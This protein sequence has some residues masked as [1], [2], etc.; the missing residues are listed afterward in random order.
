MQTRSALRVMG[1]S[2]APEAA[3]AP[4][5]SV[6]GPA[7]RSL[8]SSDAELNIPRMP[9]SPEPQKHGLQAFASV[10]P[11]NSEELQGTAGSPTLRTTPQPS[12]GGRLGKFTSFKQ[13]SGRLTQSVVAIGRSGSRVLGFRSRTE[14]DALRALNF[15]RSI[16]RAVR[17]RRKLG[18]RTRVM[19]FLVRSAALLHCPPHPH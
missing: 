10:G 18:V 9:D 17:R 1:P 3:I 12:S 6:D 15:D 8:T 11:V 16:S 7:D 13:S 5:V 19:H 4:V 14:P 2:S